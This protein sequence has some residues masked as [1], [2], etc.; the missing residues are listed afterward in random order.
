M[1]VSVVV[2]SI[3]S[4]RPRMSVI[5]RPPRVSARC[6]RHRPRSSISTTSMSPSRRARRCTVPGVTPY[7]CSIVLLTASPVAMISA[8]AR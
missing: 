6:G 2:M 5:P 1:P 3:E 7:A 4:T 8:D